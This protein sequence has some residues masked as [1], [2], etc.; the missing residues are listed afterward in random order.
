MT[1]KTQHSPL[2]LSLGQVEPLQNSQVLGVLVATGGSKS[3]VG[4]LDKQMKMTTMMMTRREKEQTKRRLVR[5][6]CY[7]PPAQILVVWGERRWKKD[8]D[9]GGEAGDAGGVQR[10]FGVDAD[11]REKKMDKMMMTMSSR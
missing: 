8:D 3:E 11:G 4:R 9:D 6:V 7:A 1:H 5:V 10:A 2:L